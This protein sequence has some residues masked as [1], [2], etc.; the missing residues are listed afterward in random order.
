MIDLDEQL[1]RLAAEVELP[2]TGP[3]DDLARGR[4]R[5][6]RHRNLGAAGAALTT[7]V[8]VGTTVAVLSGGG[9]RSGAGPGYAGAPST[10]VADATLTDSGDDA[11]RQAQLDALAA[12]AASAEVD[13]RLRQAQGHGL[14]S[15]AEARSP[16]TKAVL[17]GYRDILREDLD[18]AGK[19]IQTSAI[20]N[21]Q[22]ADDALGT[23]LEWKGGG[24]LQI[25]VGK[26]LE[27]VQ[28]FCDNAC[29]PGSVAGASKALVLASPGRISV[30]VF[31]DDG[32]IVA[33][34]ADTSFGNNG[35]STS[36]LGL[37]VDQL[38]T[39]AADPRL[40]LPD[41]TGQPAGGVGTQ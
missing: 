11:D 13:A 29:T 37:T 22:G 33:L 9:G 41:Q 20:T 38:L 24:M 30:A 12:E 19:R 3:D 4:R 2:A 8:V 5:L 21:E 31:Q 32:D 18:P 35:T 39:A 15:L 16:R 1:R 27:G 23:K 7:A 36:S 28:F 17:A 25:A 26:S 34:T 6:R 14:G 10:P 40:D